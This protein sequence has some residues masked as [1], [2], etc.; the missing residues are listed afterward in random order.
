MGW[1]MYSYG[2]ELAL[3]LPVECATPTVLK[4]QRTTWEDVAR[5]KSASHSVACDGMGE[6]KD[7]QAYSSKLFT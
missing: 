6:D 3:V 7:G 5:S 1:F 2:Q 4:W